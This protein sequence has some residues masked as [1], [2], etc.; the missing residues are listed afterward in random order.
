MALDPA[1]L[2][3]RVATSINGAVELAK[4]LQHQVL[5]PVHLAVVLFEE[6][7]GRAPSTVHLGSLKSLAAQCVSF[8]ALL[9]TPASPRLLDLH[10]IACF[11]AGI[12]IVGQQC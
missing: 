5:T 9:T 8:A 7:Q 2:T 1:K 10:H 6:P 3:E 11:S 12:N 4:E